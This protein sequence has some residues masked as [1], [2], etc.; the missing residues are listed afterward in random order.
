MNNMS[1]GNIVAACC[2]LLCFCLSGCSSSLEGLEGEVKD[3]F[4]A[5]LIKVNSNDTLGKVLSRYSYAKKISFEYEDT[6]IAEYQYVFIE[7]DL[8]KK[9]YLPI[10]KTSPSNV[11]AYVILKF[12]KTRTTSPRHLLPFPGSRVGVVMK[13]KEFMDNMSEHLFYQTLHELFNNE[14]ITAPFQTL[15]WR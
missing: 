10:I 13:G 14:P 5:N 4:V 8:E 2:I 6:D 9:E 3:I 1:H 12:A 11:E 7:L 15:Y